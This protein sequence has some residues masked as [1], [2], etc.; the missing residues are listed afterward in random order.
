MSITTT[1][2]EVDYVGNGT[3]KVFPTTFEF[4]DAATVKVT[5]GGVLLTSGY[6]VTGAGEEGGGDVTFDTAPAATSAI[7]IR[8]VLPFTQEIEPIDNATVFSSVLSRGLDTT[9]MLV[10][11]L[12]Q[13]LEDALGPVIPSVEAAEAAAAAATLAAAE[14][15]A[16]VAGIDAAVA[17]KLDLGGG[18]VGGNAAT[19]RANIGLGNVSNTSD[20]N[21]PISTAAQSALDLKVNLA[22][23]GQPNGVASLDATGKVPSSQLPTGGGAV[24]SVAGRAGDVVLTKA[25]VG[26]ANVDNTSDLNKPISTAMQGA[27]DAKAGL[28]GAAFTG[29]VS[30][31]TKAAFLR[32]ETSVLPTQNRANDYGQV[33]AANTHLCVVQGTVSAPITNEQW[34]RPMAYFERHV[35]GR[36]SAPPSDLIDANLDSNWLLAPTLL[37]QT[38]IGTNGSNA[39][40]G[41]HSRVVSDTAIGSTPTATGSLN[42]V[43][44]ELSVNCLC[45]YVGTVRVN[46]PA[47][48]KA[49]PAWVQN[50]ECVWQTGLAP[51]NLVGVEIDMINTGGGSTNPLPSAQNNFTGVWLQS[52]PRGSSESVKKYA[53]TGIYI[54]HA[55]L[56]GMGWQAGLVMRTNIGSYG[57][58]FENLSASDTPTGV[59]LS[60]GWDFGLRAV[61]NFNT[62]FLR[63][64]GSCGS[65]IADLQNTRTSATSGAGHGIKVAINRSNDDTTICEFLSPIGF[66]F[67]ATGDAT[68]PIRLRAGGEL[69][70]VTTAT[71]S[72]YTALVFI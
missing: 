21:K 30:F 69:R 62:N 38:I 40:A 49:R 27:L 37:V 47:G 60:G 48:Q 61:G 22:A 56:A 9:T 42:Q 3:T 6:S 5:V 18:N 13:E 44:M 20:A 65:Y 7:N 33:T 59:F 10:Q 29:D 70:R 15:T 24:T 19:L 43:G 41:I 32:A 57:A 12:S 8:R 39:N 68:N 66:A 14:A 36:M 53:T 64:E 23:V 11:Q 1:T 31:A 50:W 58:Y 25:D 17:G 63:A 16:A 35:A 34:A 71:I 51:D 54:A 67:Y 55:G 52:A 4:L 72:G 45:A 28:A 46:A 26:L 2:V